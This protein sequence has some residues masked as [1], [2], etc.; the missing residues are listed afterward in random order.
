MQPEC[1]MCTGEYYAI[2]AL[3][4]PACKCGIIERHGDESC[5]ILLYIEQSEWINNQNEHIPIQNSQEF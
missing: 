3:K 4:D 5:L 1:A 2:H